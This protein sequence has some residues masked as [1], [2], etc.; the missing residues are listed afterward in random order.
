MLT[1]IYDL[2]DL[3]IFFLL[4]RLYTVLSLLR[5]SHADDATSYRFAEMGVHEICQKIGQSA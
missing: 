5:F 4:Y 2:T 3:E 1:E